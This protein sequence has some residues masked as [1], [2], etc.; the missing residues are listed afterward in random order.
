MLK[1][2][3]A[4]FPIFFL[5]HLSFS[6]LPCPLIYFILKFISFTFLFDIL[7][8]HFLANPFDSEVT[9]LIP[10]QIYL[11]VLEYNYCSVFFK[12]S[13]S[14]FWICFNIVPDFSTLVK[15]MILNSVLPIMYFIRSNINFQK[16]FW[17][18]LWSI[19]P[20]LKTPHGNMIK[21]NSCML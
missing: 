3:S 2:C 11:E 13:F 17:E 9:M 16:I 7:Q 4:Y 10:P 15:T 8:Q 14:N 5:L 21:I 6:Y 20:G 1:S 19:G 12:I 18:S